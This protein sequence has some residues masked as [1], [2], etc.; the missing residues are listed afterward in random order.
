MTIFSN[1]PDK[2]S[3]IGHIS[4]IDFS[5]NSGY[6]VCGNE[7]GQAFLYKLNHYEKP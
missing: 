1:F 6:F 3:L 2:H 5:P 7:K 4:C